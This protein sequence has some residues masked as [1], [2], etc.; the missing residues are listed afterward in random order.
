M[1]LASVEWTAH[2]VWSFVVTLYAVL[3]E[4][5]K[6]CLPDTGPCPEPAE[7]RQRSHS[8]F[9]LSVFPVNAQEPVTSPV[10]LLGSILAVSILFFPTVCI[11]LLTMKFSCHLYIPVCMFTICLIL[12]VQPYPCWDFSGQIILFIFIFW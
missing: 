5:G 9:L 7:S 11:C 8:L 4:K 1:W 6:S 2:R 10:H 12:F 3:V